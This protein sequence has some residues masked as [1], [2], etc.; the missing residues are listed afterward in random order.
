[1]PFQN[2]VYKL[3]GVN[4]EKLIEAFS[5]VLDEYQTQQENASSSHL[6]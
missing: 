5:A 3:L 4:Y 2:G 6:L 1:M